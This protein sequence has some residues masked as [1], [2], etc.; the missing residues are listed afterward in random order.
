MQPIVLT[1]MHRSGTS[2]VASLFAQAGIAMGDR[3]LRGSPHN[4]K[5]YFEDTDFFTLHGEML[6]AACGSGEGWPDWGWTTDEA[7]QR[8]AFGDF[9]DRA[10]YLLIERA[11]R[12]R[13]GWKDPRS[14]LVLDFWHDLVPEAKHVFIFREPWDVAD[15]LHRL[16]DFPPFNDPS[17]SLRIWCYYN[18][19]LLDFARRHPGACFFLPLELAR[20]L[21][22]AAVRLALAHLG[23]EV[24]ETASAAT[25]FESALLTTRRVDSAFLAGFA[26]REPGAWQLWNELNRTAAAQF[27]LPAAPKPAGPRLSI[28]IPC[29]NDGSFLL[30]S[31]ASVAASTSRESETLIVDDGS[32]SGFTQALLTRASEAGWTV[33]H[34]EARGLSAARNRGIRAARG[35][36]VLPLDA[37]NR[38]KPDFPEAAMAI[39]DTR[40][41]V[42]VVYGDSEFFGLREGRECLPDFD[43]ARLHV[44]NYIDACAVFRR[45]HWEEAGGY[46]ESFVGYEDWDLW[47]SFA[48][49]GV[50]FFHLP[51]LAFE[52][53]VRPDS[54]L[55]Q[56]THPEAH[57]ALVRKLAAKHGFYKEHLPQLVGD[58]HRLWIG[59]RDARRAGQQEIE[60]LRLELEDARRSIHQIEASQAGRPIEQPEKPG[61]PTPID[62]PNEGF[63]QLRAL[64]EHLPNAAERLHRSRRWWLA[65]PGVFLHHLLDRKRP[66]PGFWP[67]D[68]LVTRLG[69]WR[70]T[71]G[72]PKALPA[73]PPLQPYEAHRLHNRPGTVLRTQMAHATARFAYRPLISLLMPVYNADL[74]W[75]RKAVASVRA[76]IYPHWQ[77][78]IADDASP[79]RRVRAYL[80]TLRRDPRIQVVFRRVNG[81]IPAACNSAADLAAGDYVAFL[82]QDDEL[83]PHALYEFA[84]VLQ[85]H[86]NADVLYSD[87][88]K[89]DTAGR[90]YD[91]HFKPDWSPELLISYN[92]INHLTAVRRSLFEEV[93]RLREGYKGSQDHDLL[94]RV[95]RRSSRI[96]HVPKVLYH[97]RALPGSTASAAS[98]KGYM[99]DS[100]RRA[101][102]D[103]LDS[104]GIEATVYTP[105]FAARGGLPIHLLDWPD[106]GPAVTILIPTHNQPALLRACVE[107]VRSLTTYR[108][109]RI[110]V[111][112]NETSDTEAL[113]YLEELDGGGKARVLRLSNEGGGFSFA[114]LHNRAVREVDGEILVFLNDDTVVREPQWLSRLVGHLSLPGVGATGAR[115]LFPDGTVQHAGIL[116]GMNDGIAPDHAFLRHPGEAISY[117]FL[118]EVTRPCAA[119]TA[120]C[121]ATRRDTFL[122]IG[123]FDE[124][125]YAVS[126]NDVDYCLRLRAAGLR[127][128]YVAG[129][130]LFH[131]QTSTRP[132]QDDPCELGHF[133]KLTRHLRDPYYNP[134]LSRRVSFTVKPES[135]FH[136]D[137]ILDRPAHVLFATHN[138]NHHEGAPAGL[139]RTAAALHRRGRVKAS[140]F[141]TQKGPLAQEF[142]RAGI[143]VL[144]EELLTRIPG[145][146]TSGWASE[147]SYEEAVE[148]LVDL[149]RGQSI[150]VVLASTLYNYPHIDAASRAGVPSVWFIQE[151]HNEAEMASLFQGDELKRCERAFAQAHSVIFSSRA[152]QSLY[153]RYDT[154]RNAVVIPNGIDPGPVDS[155]CAAVTREAAQRLI[156]ADTSRKQIVMVGTVCERKNQKLLVEAAILLGSER[157]DFCC[158]LVGAREEIACVKE[159]RDRIREAGAEDIVRLVPETPDVFAYLRAADLFAFTSLGESFSLALMEAQAFGLPILTTA[160]PG[161]AEQVIFNVNA[162]EIDPSDAPALARR[163]AMLL[164]DEA[165]RQRMG[166]S[167]RDVFDLRISH[168]EMHDRFEHAVLGAWLHG[169]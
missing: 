112:D 150:D 117:Y 74:R 70:E 9:R 39:L 118:A 116:L 5:G 114:R 1:G 109:Y 142:L 49:R 99:P 53:R 110:V 143:P 36:F 160:C 69:I 107:S 3:L 25:T 10:R 96:H 125:R 137:V 29:Y 28:V 52:Y 61:D 151:S 86:P 119:V 55:T 102:Q 45:R 63:E 91:P 106:D 16:G 139:F 51:E 79:D 41:D 85:D 12:Q 144:R 30:E 19:H 87:E 13:W 60:T 89:I 65:N 97:W 47:L 146:I 136:E 18:R 81:H 155:Y 68:E 72:A 77:L 21:G 67:V 83:A 148:K 141:C 145:T 115:L 140:V 56:V 78:C 169:S 34:Q 37:D 26:G 33:L 156:G 75:L 6:R 126:M 121:L 113:R 76:Q 54:L 104:L 48:A 17:A 14:T 40:T 129:A 135:V 38:I 168:D 57:A 103:H 20:H 15:S 133:R 84:R 93:G 62:A 149:I 59:E 100:D 131:H 90:R 98:V 31:L 124:A 2:F 58:L 95:S 43:P 94:L 32:T 154:L 166:S 101:V 132:A 159:L 71:F 120:A 46:D 44:G 35:E 152:T 88:D 105:E 111:I 66:L 23:I 108:N 147:E 163:I 8:E 80:R 134:N 122:S 50:G 158:H 130:E 7:L 161:A 164:D 42:G 138:L 24:A 157:R 82:D 73:P 123:G 167:S 128:V 22:P 153:E 127:A 92:Y 11:G 64:M 27:V 4:P 162:L 165:R